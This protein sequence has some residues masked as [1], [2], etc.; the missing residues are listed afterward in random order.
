VTPAER[1]PTLDSEGVPDLE[2]PLPEK[3]LTG[4]PQE[5][6]AAPS[7]RPRASVDW[8]VTAEEQ[9]ELEPLDVRV[10]R[11]LPDIGATDPVDEVAEDLGLDRQPLD[12]V[13]EIIEAAGSLD[14]DDVEVDDLDALELVGDDILADDEKDLVA[15]AVPSDPDLGYSPEEEAVH[16][17]DED[18]L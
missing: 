2:G 13:D 18:D 1:E 4:D 14:D 7:D 11:E 8:G 17:I 9:R 6:I 12:D 5:G 3:E 10:G 15:L 16:I